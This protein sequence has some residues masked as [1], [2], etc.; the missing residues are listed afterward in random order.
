MAA[1]LMVVNVLPSPGPLE[2]TKMV[3]FGAL[4][5]TYCRLV[6][7]VRNASETN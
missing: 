4:R 1:I 5:N 7:S 6:R 3:L 2:V